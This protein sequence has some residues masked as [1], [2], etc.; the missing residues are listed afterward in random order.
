MQS[1]VDLVAH[2]G[3]AQSKL[4]IMYDNP[5]NLIASDDHELTWVEESDNPPTIHLDDMTYALSKVQCHIGSEHTVDGFRYAGSCHF[6]HQVGNKY[7]I[8]AVFINDGASTTNAAFDDA[9]EDTNLLWS[10]MISELDLRYYWE[11]T[12]SFT[13]PNCEEDVQWII[14]R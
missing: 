13:T 5:T 2:S 1:P 8:I 10:T 3:R 4:D 6:V 12:G 11:Y 9:L 7:V 14:L